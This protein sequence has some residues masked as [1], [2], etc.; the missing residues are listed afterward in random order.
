RTNWLAFSADSKTLFAASGSTVGN[1]AKEGEI[2]RWDV[3]TFREAAD[4][5]KFATPVWAAAFAPAQKRAAWGLGEGKAR[6]WD[7]AGGKPGPLLDGLGHVTCCLA[8]SPD[9]KLL[10]GGSHAG[11]VVWDAAGKAT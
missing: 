9:G 3:G 4:P 8:F 11:V 7:L 6:L 2:R 10:A 1:S 5:Q